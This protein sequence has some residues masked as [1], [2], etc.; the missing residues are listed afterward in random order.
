MYEEKYEEAI[1]KI[2][3]VYPQ[4]KDVR[5][6]LENGEI[7][8]IMDSRFDVDIHKLQLFVNDFLGQKVF[9]TEYVGYI[10]VYARSENE[11]REF[12]RDIKPLTNI[13]K[14]TETFLKRVECY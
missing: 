3:E 7:G 11:A 10:D 9:R 2:K 12:T 6:T 1:N 5:F 4:F 8:W 14:I 13:K